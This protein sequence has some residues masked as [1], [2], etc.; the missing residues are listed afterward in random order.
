MCIV[1]NAQI[2]N[3]PDANFKAYLLSANTTNYIAL[4]ANN[5]PIVINSNGDN[6]IQLSEASLVKTLDISG[7][8]STVGSQI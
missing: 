8:S 7:S 2:V 3:I 1:S 4:D 6:E 5:N